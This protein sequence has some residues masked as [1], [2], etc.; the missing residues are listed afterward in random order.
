MFKVYH[1]DWGWLAMMPRP[2]IVGQWIREHTEAT[3]PVFQYANEASLR[4][5]LR[6]HWAKG[7]VKYMEIKAVHRAQA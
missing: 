1:P 5:A 4:R 6:K 3:A 2:N 7:I